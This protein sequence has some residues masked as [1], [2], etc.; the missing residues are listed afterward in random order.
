M[1]R[2]RLTEGNLIDEYERIVGLPLEHAYPAHQRA[3][4]VEGVVVSRFDDSVITV[5]VFY[6]DRAAVIGVTIANGSVCAAQKDEVTYLF[7]G[8]KLQVFVME[9]GRHSRIRLWK[10]CRW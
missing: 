1:V 3:G 9:D 8:G 7:R 10:T 4:D 5:H 6:F 2:E